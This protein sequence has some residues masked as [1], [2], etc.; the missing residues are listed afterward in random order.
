MLVIIPACGRGERF[1]KQGYELIKPLIPVMGRTMIDAVVE[2]LYLDVMRG[3]ECV[4]VTNFKVELKGHR[5]VQ[6]SRETLGATETVILALESFGDAVFDVSGSSLLLLDCDAIYHCDIISKFRE[7][8]IRR[9]VRAAVLCFEESVDDRA[10][11]AKYSYVMASDGDGRVT[12][13]AEKSR[14]GPYANTGVY[15]FASV[16]EFYEC[17]KD[18]VVNRKFE[19]GE[20]YVSCVLK[21]YI[22]RDQHVSSVLIAQNQ[23]SNIGTPECL[24]T[25][26]SKQE[27]AFLFDLDGT[28]ID[29]T[30]AYVKAWNELLRPMGA[31]VDEEFFLTHISGKSDKQVSQRFNIDIS[32]EEK[33]ECF[34]R[35]ISLAKEVPGAVHFV[36]TCQTQGLV[37]VVTNSNATAAKALLKQLALDNLPLISS[38]DCNHGKPNA[39]PYNKAARLLGVSM[40]KSIVFED[41]RTGMIAGRAAGCKY[42]VSVRN[43][44]AGSDAFCLDYLDATPKD[45]LDTL[46]S[47]AHLSEE[48]SEKLGQRS[49]VYPVRASGGYISEILSATSGTRRLVVKQENSDHGVLNDVS[50]HLNL[51]S[52]ECVFY[53][54]FASTI[55]VR[56]PTC[57]GILPQSRA[58]IMEDLRKFD[59][60]PEFELE[61]GLKVVKTIAKMHSHFRGTPLGRLN[62]P[63]LYMRYHV[64]R[65]YAAFRTRWSRTLGE[66]TLA[67]FEHATKNLVEAESQLKRVPRTLLHGDLKFPISSGTIT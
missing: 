33:D 23:F 46:N 50:E 2:A 44:L 43:N 56:V 35:Y 11:I 39:E 32:S 37:C 20:A 62:K 24:E 5:V 41:S 1:K 42:V 18:V 19:K 17:A 30:A 15:W 67:L 60:A 25:Y 61:S 51:H 21:E 63:N 9:D 64:E 22:A 38:D 13:I 27:H 36:R 34:V 12:A 10:A 52:T 4:V 29:T 16:A 31:F 7:L 6:L 59:R 45:L 54:D 57:Y 3:D 48:L 65:H 55:P 26:L 40:S 28:L 8:E 49:I 14:V 58:I 47:V 66:D 53:E